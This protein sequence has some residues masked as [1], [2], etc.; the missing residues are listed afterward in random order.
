MYGSE[1]IFFEC[2][3]VASGV[4]GLNSKS[5]LDGPVYSG[6]ECVFK[7][8]H[9]SLEQWNGEKNVPAKAFYFFL[10]L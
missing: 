9:S 7:A 4:F 10:V 3:G 5:Y 8:N 6:N 1:N 2:S